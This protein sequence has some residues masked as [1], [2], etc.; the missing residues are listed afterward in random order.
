MFYSKYIYNRAKIYVTLH[1]KVFKHPPKRDIHKG[2][3]TVKVAKS[4]KLCSFSNH[5]PKNNQYNP[6]Q[7][8]F[9]HSILKI[10]RK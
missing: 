8:V 9:G 5:L 1:L 7:F 6:R 10:G 3:V 4:R 2:N